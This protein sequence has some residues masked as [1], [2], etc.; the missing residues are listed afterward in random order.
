MS[1]QYQICP[2]DYDY[3]FKITLIGDS[4]VGKSNILHRYTSN[5]FSIE[6]KSTIGVEFAS[7]TETIN[8][9]TVR[10]QIWDTAGQE[11]YI[12]ITGAYYRGASGVIVVYDIAKRSTFN[13]LS[14]WLKE[15]NDHVSANTVI[16]LVGNKSDVLNRDVTFDEAQQFAKDNNVSFFEVSALTGTGIADIFIHL[17]NEIHTIVNPIL[18][19]S[20][21]LQNHYQTG[22]N[23]NPI[24]KETVNNLIP[25]KSCC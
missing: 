25:S 17:A 11:R 6:N 24:S 12:A 1:Q 18:L 22:G 4:G 8:E 10:L 3:L 9:N 23:T 15:I 21:T 14:L 7:K 20:K 19:D 5:T 16:V 2:V 13:N